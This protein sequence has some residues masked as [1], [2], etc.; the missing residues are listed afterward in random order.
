[1]NMF[2]GRHTLRP[3]LGGVDFPLSRPEIYS[4]YSRQIEDFECI[5]EVLN[6]RARG[7]GQTNDLCDQWR[8]VSSQD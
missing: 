1:M 5:E 4:G 2:S 8:M 3:T 7:R 6:Q